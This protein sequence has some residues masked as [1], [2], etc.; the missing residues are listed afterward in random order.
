M[1][2]KSNLPVFILLVRSVDA[3]ACACYAP[4][5]M[6]PAATTALMT[7][8]EMCDQFIAQKYLSQR[9][10]KQS[11]RDILCQMQSFISIR[12]K[13][14]DN[15]F[16]EVFTVPSKPDVSVLFVMGVDGSIF[17]HGECHECSNRHVLFHHKID[18]EEFIATFCIR[19]IVKHLAR[20]A[21]YEWMGI[22]NLTNVVNP[23]ETA[24]A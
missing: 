2:G 19:N 20:I 8:V 13:K 17:A 14:E 11:L 24:Q 9:E 22:R 5:R 15:V 6:T 18:I 3:R 4:K 1:N 12:H 16:L 21:R 10:Q 23:K 7:L